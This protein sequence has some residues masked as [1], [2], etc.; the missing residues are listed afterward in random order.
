MN[1]T[2]EKGKPWLIW[3]AII[4]V[5]V[6][7]F[8]FFVFAFS[9]A[10]AAKTTALSAAQVPTQPTPLVNSAPIAKVPAVV[11]PI[12]VSTAV[13]KSDWVWDGTVGG[14][15]EYIINGDPAIDGFLVKGAVMKYT[16]TKDFGVFV[17]GDPMNVNR[18]STGDKGAAVFVPG[19]KGDVIT[20][21]TTFW[22]AN[23]PNNKHQS[24]HLFELVQA[25]PNVNPANILAALKRDEKKP[26]SYLFKPDGTYDTITV[27][28]PQPAQAAVRPPVDPNFVWDQKIGSLGCC[29]VDGD[30]AIDGFLVKGAVMKY[31]MIG[32]LGVF[33]SGDPLIINGVSTGN[34]GAAVF[35]PGKKGD[36][37]TITTTFWDDNSKHQSIHLFELVQAV[38]NVNPENILMVLKKTENKPIAL[39]FKIDGTYFIK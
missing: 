14:L 9:K 17:C 1:K 32:D 33:V 23:D 30:P 3:T 36:V 27:D 2:S 7:V 31:I 22:N 28:I 11:V 10:M 13:L 21:T 25:V 39:M 20:I 29:V 19:K 6:V 37:I 12:A 5:G 8:G 26:I 18:L 4:L 24:I 15:G 35:V 38:P 16:L 34:K